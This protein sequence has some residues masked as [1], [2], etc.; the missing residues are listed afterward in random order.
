MLKKNEKFNP[1]NPKLKIVLG[2]SALNIK[3]D[4]NKKE[5]Q[6]TSVKAFLGK[7]P[8]EWL[9]KYPGLL[10]NVPEFENNAFGAGTISLAQEPDGIIRR[11]PLISNI[12]DSIRPALALEMIRVAFQGNSIATKT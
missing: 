5:L 1:K 9:P 4:E 6:E 10:A 12:A 7:S 11:V 2:H 8:T 3:S